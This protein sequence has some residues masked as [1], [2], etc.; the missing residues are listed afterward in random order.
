MKT[1][2]ILYFMVSFCICISFANTYGQH[3]LKNGRDV[4]EVYQKFPGR[5]DTLLSSIDLDFNGLEKVKT[6]RA[7]GDVVAACKELL[8]YFHDA[9]TAQFLRREIPAP[10][11]QTVPGADSI[12]QGI[13]TFYDAPA[14]VPSRLSGRLDW[15]YRGPADDIEWAWGLNRHY[16]LQTL[17][18]AYFK[19]GNAVY[20][21]TIDLHIRDWVISSLPYPAKKSSTEMW[22]GLEVSFRV[23]V[24]ARVFFGL[25]ESGYLSPATQLLLL[26]SLTEHTHY[27]RN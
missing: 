26:T 4:E 5:V 14:A 3:D 16:H 18:D 20:A 9:K 23:K 25:M 17:L 6:A 15:N 22:R 13:F 2:R 7:A 24:W 1:E 10:S 8:N 19:T 21:K 27:L 11:T 12:L